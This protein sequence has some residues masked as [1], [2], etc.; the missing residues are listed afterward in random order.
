MAKPPGHVTRLDDLMRKTEQ[1][2]RDEREHVEQDSKSLQR[3]L[4]VVG[5]YQDFIAKQE[6]I[7]NQQ[8]E[9]L[10]QREEVLEMQEALL[11]NRKIHIW[12]DEQVLEQA[13]RKKGFVN[14]EVQGSVLE[15]NESEAEDS[16][17]AQ[18]LSDE[19][20]DDIR[21]EFK[22]T[23]LETVAKI[24]PKVR[25]L[26]AAALITASILAEVY[27]DPVT[28][29]LFEPQGTPP[30]R[31][32]K[33][34]PEQE[35]EA[36]TRG[37]SAQKQFEFNPARNWSP[38]AR[39]LPTSYWRRPLEFCGLPPKPMPEWLRKPRSGQTD[40]ADKANVADKADKKE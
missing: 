16:A 7:L 17:P 24:D 38:K 28:S 31:M 21:Y 8:K 25:E 39:D 13:E 35:A 18:H 36:D 40:K 37:R 14:R 26:A 5:E 20:L 32:G 27:T 9:L 3:D 12:A 4:Q 23:V 11:N 2:L 29:A 22:K 15:Q 34:V 1:R 33:K 10:R 6:K 30:K 19:E